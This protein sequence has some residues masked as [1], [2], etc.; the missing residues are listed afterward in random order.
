[1]IHDFWVPQ[2]GRK[3]DAIPGHPSF[4][5]MQADAAGTYLGACAEYCGAQHAWMRIVVIAEAQADFDAWDR[6]Q[7]EPAPTSAMSGPALRGE[8]TFRG[9]TCVNCHAVAGEGVPAR[10]APDLTHLAQRTTLG[11][12]VLTNDPPSL[13]RWLADPQGV[14]PGSH[15]P[16][17]NLTDAEVSDLVAY[18]EMLR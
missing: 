4:V 16:D 17:L 12:G 13:T 5:W 18:L 14:K 1:V 11:A 6:H 2:L 8:A 15:M 7:R 10:V 3:V 9:R